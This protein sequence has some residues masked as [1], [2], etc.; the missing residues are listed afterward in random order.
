VLAM[1]GAKI[2]PW[3]LVEKLGEGGMGSVWRGTHD[4]LA[5]VAAF[6]ILDPRFTQNAALVTRFV[7]EARAIS[8]VKHRNLVEVFNI[9]RTP[10]G[11][12]YIELEYLQGQTLGSYLARLGGPVSPHRVVNIAG[13]IANVMGKMHVEHKIVHRDLKPDNIFLVEHP[14]Y[15]QLVKVLDFGVASLNESFGN[16]PSRSGL[17]IG[18]PFYM[19]QEQ[20]RGN[21]VTPAADTYALGV[22]LY[23]MLTCLLPQQRDDESRAQYFMLGLEELYARHAAPALSPSDRIP[24]IP[25][26]ISRV[27]MRMLDPDPRLRYP[28]IHAAAY[29]LAEATAGKRTTIQRTW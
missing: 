12:H 2:G 28:T 6:K 16:A 4:L 21:S 26:E 10:W 14:V 24:G 22:I 13:Q 8:K 25:A 9:D 27:V 11:D 23:E 18:T 7:N 17:V 5:R 29:A 3:T 20:L 19:P 1:I 15:E